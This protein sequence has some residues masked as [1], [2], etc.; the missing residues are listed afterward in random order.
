MRQQAMKRSV[1]LTSRKIINSKLKEAVDSVVPI[2][3]I[4]AVL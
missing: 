1:I 2:T 4:V 3:L